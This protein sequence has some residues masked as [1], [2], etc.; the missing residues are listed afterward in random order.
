MVKARFVTTKESKESV[1]ETPLS[2]VGSENETDEE[3]KCNSAPIRVALETKR[4]LERI[5]ELIAQDGGRK[6]V[7]F[8]SVIRHAL[9]K[10]KDQDLEELR[11][12]TVSYGEL[13]DREFQRHKVE[14]GSVTRDEFL[15]MVLLGKVKVRTAAM[16]AK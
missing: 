2:I 12:K 5:V 1:S 6:K 7:K 14:H 9:A 15:G 3:A 4:E 11:S 10:L 13:F 8:D 16:L